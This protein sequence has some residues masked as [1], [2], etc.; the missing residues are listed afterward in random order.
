M[1]AHQVLVEHLPVRRWFGLR[2]TCSR[3]GARY[4]CAARAAAL[5]E[6]AGRA[7]WWSE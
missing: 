2:L 5:D 7:Y 4:P 3:C 1:A 6:L